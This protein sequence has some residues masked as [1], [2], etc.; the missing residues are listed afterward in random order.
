[1]E[2]SVDLVA[3]LKS[4]LVLISF[5]LNCYITIATNLVS[6]NRLLAEENLFN[7]MPCKMVFNMELKCCYFIIFGAVIIMAKLIKNTCALLLW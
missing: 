5:V 7:L 4:K 2:L 6:I 1:M 3:Q